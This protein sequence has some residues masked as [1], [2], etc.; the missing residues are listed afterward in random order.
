MRSKLIFSG[1]GD[2]LQA[3]I[4]LVQAVRDLQR[5]KVSHRIRIENMNELDSG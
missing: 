1:A 2:V 3:F 4:E 5:K